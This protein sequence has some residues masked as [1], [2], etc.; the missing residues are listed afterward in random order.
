MSL[1][2]L[3]K[4]SCHFSVNTPECPKSE[5]RERIHTLKNRTV[6][7]KAQIEQ[8]DEQY[9]ASKQYIAFQRYRLMKSMVKVLLTNCIDLQH[10]N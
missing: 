8:L 5:L 3:V 10:N 7:L 9:E 1:E 4:T 6:F 2:R